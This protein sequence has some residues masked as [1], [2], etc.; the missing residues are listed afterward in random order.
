MPFDVLFPTPNRGGLPKIVIESR[1][2]PSV[3]LSMR[4]RIA[5]VEQEQVG[6][7]RLWSAWRR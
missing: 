6:T 4:V 3:P 7:E 5:V 1:P 2:A